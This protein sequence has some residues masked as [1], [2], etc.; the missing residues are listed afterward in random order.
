MAGSDLFTGSLDLLILKALQWGPLHGYA[1]GRWIRH[2]TETVL[3]VQEGAL[4]PAL[5]RLEKR[6]LL[7]EEWGI[8]E[9]NREAKFY[10]LTRAGRQHLR[11][12]SSRFGDYARVMTAALAASRP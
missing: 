7:A 12:Q 5:H 4:Y 3:T 6:G 2:W 11:E 9:T 10:S 1:I 8:S